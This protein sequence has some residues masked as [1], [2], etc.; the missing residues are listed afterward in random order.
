MSVERKFRSAINGF[1]RQDVANYI[2]SASARAAATKAEKEKLQTRCTQLE[3][4]LDAAERRA[5][6]AAARC[7]EL[8]VQL[9]QLQDDYDHARRELENERTEKELLASASVSGEELLAL[10]RALEEA[11]EKLT[12]QEEEL[13]DCRAKAAE[14]DAV[15][16]RVASLE[17]S[18][19]RRAV[20][21][22]RAAEEKA[23][24]VLQNAREAETAAEQARE[25][26]AMRYRSQLQKLG[27]DS[28]FGAAL[29][30]KELTQLTESLNQLA[31]ELDTAAADFD[32]APGSTGYVPE[33]ALEEN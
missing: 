21:I 2:E 33:A 27:R 15:K 20:E 10:R 28:R 24:Q 13:S 12:Q 29:L 32:A 6:E 22:E 1:N 31:S 16:E 3:A 14:Y 5:A 26:A 9:S 4:A 25:A 19:S 30:T 17:L 8:E 7:G 23:A 11:E 18:A